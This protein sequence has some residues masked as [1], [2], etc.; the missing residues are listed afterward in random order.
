MPTV[1]WCDSAGQEVDRFTSYR[2][3]DEFLEIVRGWRK[4]RTIDR[5][6]A[7]QQ[8]RHRRKTPPCCWTWPVGTP[9]GARTSEADIQY[10]R[11]MNLRHEADTRTV[12]RGMLGLAELEE[13]AGNTATSQTSGGAG[14]GTLCGRPNPT[15]EMLAYRTEGLMEIALF[16]E[17]RGDTLGVLETYRTMVATG[18]PG[19]SGSGRVRP[20][21][22]C[23]AGGT[24]GGHALR[25]ARDGFQRQG[26][27]HHQH[28]G[29]DLLPSAVCTAR[30][31]GGSILPSNEIPPTPHYRDRL[32]VFET[33]QV[34]ARYRIYTEFRI[35]YSMNQ[36]IK[37]GPAPYNGAGPTACRWGIGGRYRQAVKF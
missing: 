4:N 15:P 30:R 37:R 8:G 24:G 19:G 13:K 3:S 22:R 14:G 34:D 33:A 23:R 6:L 35:K 17:D 25:L 12:A 26:C 21:G 2:S 11:L 16:Q 31:S 27:A 28:S 20:H 7:E 18:R 5:M 9:S 32:A 1:V 29:R 36:G 10:R